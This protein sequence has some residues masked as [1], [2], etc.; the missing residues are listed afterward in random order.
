MQAD[1]GAKRSPFWQALGRALL[2]GHVRVADTQELH[3]AMMAPCMGRRLGERWMMQEYSSW[4]RLF[5]ARA[6]VQVKDWC[7]ARRGVAVE[8][9]REQQKEPFVSTSQKS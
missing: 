9:E 2:A 4:Q 7:R 6:W 8:G 3:M 5:R 1:T